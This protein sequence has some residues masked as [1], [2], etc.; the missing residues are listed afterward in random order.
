M[1]W[2]VSLQGP[3]VLRSG[4]RVCVRACV[5]VFVR[6]PRPSSRR[7]VPGL[8]GVG[9]GPELA[10]EAAALSPLRGPAGAGS[11]WLRVGGRWR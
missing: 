7:R 6:A 1:G 8:R 2:G 3:G 10:G 11:G 4:V 9:A 5:C